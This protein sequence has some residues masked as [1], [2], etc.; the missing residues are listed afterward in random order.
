MIALAILVAVLRD[1]TAPTDQ[2]GLV[3]AAGVASAVG[4]SRRMVGTGGRPKVWGLKEIKKLVIIDRGAGCL[5]AEWW[6]AQRM[7]VY[8]YGW[9]LTRAGN[10]GETGVGPTKN[11]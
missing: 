3:A 2:L 10:A 8:A 4:H 1:P 5:R 7:R 11:N 6:C 9:T